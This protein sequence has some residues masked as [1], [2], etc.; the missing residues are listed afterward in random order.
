MQAWLLVGGGGGG[1]TGGATA[2]D[3]VHQTSID[4]SRPYGSSQVPDVPH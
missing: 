3:C 2:S 4:L 1:R